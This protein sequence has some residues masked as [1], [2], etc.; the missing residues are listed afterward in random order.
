MMRRV[1]LRLIRHFPRPSMTS[2]LPQTTSASA[3]SATRASM[4]WQW[5][6]RSNGTQKPQV[7]QSAGRRA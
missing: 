6:L 1:V 2:Q 7:R 3:P 5:N 4:S